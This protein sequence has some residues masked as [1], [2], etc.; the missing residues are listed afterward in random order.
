ML[1]NFT[2]GYKIPLHVCCASSV[3][4]QALY[5]IAY[6]ANFLYLILIGRMVNGCAFTMFMYCKRYCSDPKIVGI[7]RRTTL[8]SWIVIG[9]GLGV[10]V[11][12]FSGGLFY[13]I[14][15]DNSIFN[16]YT[17]P[18]WILA[19]IWCLFWVAVVRWYEDED[20]V[21]QDEQES[22]EMSL[23]AEPP[24]ILIPASTQS[25]SEEAG[26]LTIVR[27]PPPSPRSSP[28]PTRDVESAHSEPRFRGLGITQW[29]V[30]ACMCW[31]AMTSFFILGAWESN[32]A[33]FGAAFQ[34]FHW[35]PY[36]A[37]NFI[38]L[39]GLV[40][41]PFLILNLLL[42][43][44]VQDRHILA[45]GTGIG[46]AALFIFLSLLK[47][48]H[49]SYGSALVCWWAI[50]LGFNMSTTVPMS[51]LSKQLPPSWNSWASLV[52][53]Y[54][55]Y[56][57]RVTG[58]IWGGSGVRVGMFKYIGLEVAFTGFGTV[59]FAT[60]WKEMKTKKG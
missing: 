34:K 29:A 52:V 7:R 21:I 40:A 47:T 8:A 60:L 13:K 51:M 31:Y 35:T 11:G 38:A 18:N 48:D 10:T 17:S 15:F 42:A 12:P 56:T 36:A 54:S 19:A 28:P 26:V 1:N 14:G 33:V 16:G 32:L 27:H 41:F 30:I 59:L 20:G 6:R 49:L 45:F 50:T 9:Q 37:G 5:A 46:S 23:P 3:L 24:S 53:Q 2:G 58:A 44:R 57:G 25:K 39:G 22:V 4:G 55:N 43:R